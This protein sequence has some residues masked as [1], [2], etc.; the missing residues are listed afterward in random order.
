MEWCL[1]I[2][3]VLLNKPFYKRALKAEKLL[4]LQTYSENA[5]TV[6]LVLHNI[7]CKG[8]LETIQMLPRRINLY[9]S[10][11]PYAGLSNCR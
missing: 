10:T 9:K 7:Q 3:I 5:V 1:I 8:C 11:E 4:L 2:G 6:V